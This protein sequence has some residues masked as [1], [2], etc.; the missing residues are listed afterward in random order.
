MP[1]A[2]LPRTYFVGLIDDGWAF[3]RPGEK[4][5]G[6]AAQLRVA[7]RRLAGP[8]ARGD[9]DERRAHTGESVVVTTIVT[10]RIIIT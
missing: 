7:V 5:V 6:H 10:T 4:A 1:V 8:F 2:P 9:S 3:C